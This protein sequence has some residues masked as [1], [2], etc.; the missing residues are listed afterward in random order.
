MLNE[1]EIREFKL[2]LAGC[3]FFLLIVTCCI[4]FGFR[5][6]HGLRPKSFRKDLCDTLSDVKKYNLIN[7]TIVFYIGLRFLVV[8]LAIFCLII[9]YRDTFAGFSWI[10]IDERGL[11]LH[12]PW[13][14][15]NKSVLFQNIKAMEHQKWG[16]RS[17]VL[18]ITTSTG[19]TFKSVSASPEDI[20]ADFRDLTNI[21]SHK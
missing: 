2:T 12:Y 7:F 6:F 19:E 11:L 4:F 9:V 16:R 15:S 17:E 21:V 14:I 13:P 18:Q 20:R 8:F 3:L 1:I 5:L 10:N